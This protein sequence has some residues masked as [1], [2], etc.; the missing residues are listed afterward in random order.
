MSEKT[1][2]ETFETQTSALVN[3]T[4]QLNV[5]SEII[6]NICSTHT[7]FSVLSDRTANLTVM[8]HG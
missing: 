4:I 8:K 6:A 5:L 1:E 7:Q 2:L 3:Q